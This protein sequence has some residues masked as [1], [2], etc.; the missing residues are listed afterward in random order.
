MNKYVTLLLCFMSTY[1]VAMQPLESTEIV[2]EPTCNFNALPLDIK[3]T[4][5]EFLGTDNESENIHV[6]LKALACADTSNHQVINDA[7]LT[8]QLITDVSKRHT[9]DAI[10][11]AYI[12]GSSEAFKT[13]CDFALRHVKTVNQAN[14]DIFKILTRPTSS[15][16]LYNFY[17]RVLARA[18]AL[19]AHLITQNK[20]YIARDTKSVEALVHT[21][22]GCRCA[23]KEHEGLN[24]LLVCIVMGP[25]WASKALKEPDIY[26]NLK[27]GLANDEDRLKS[28]LASWFRILCNSNDIVG[29]SAVLKYA[30]ALHIL[31]HIINVEKLIPNLTKATKAGSNELVTLL[32]S[33]KPRSVGANTARELVGWQC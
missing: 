20:T 5:V 33:Y 23:G 28:I 25:L 30:Q 27:E 1:I 22:I 13:I 17:K 6:H 11:A 2:A 29:V 10:D 12:V 8:K 31:D 32:L 15:Q 9:V 3:K 19:K 4:I 18:N 7:D 21:I 14:C 26:S 16:D 24:E